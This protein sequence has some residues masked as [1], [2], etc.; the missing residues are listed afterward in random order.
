MTDPQEALRRVIETDVLGPRLRDQIAVL[1]LSADDPL[2]VARAD[3]LYLWDDYHTEMLDFAMT[4]SPLGHRHA[5]IIGTL[6]EH[7]NHYGFT[8]PQ[9]Q[10]ALRWPVLYAKD[11]SDSFS[12][13]S[14]A[15]KVLFCEGS[16][17][18]ISQAVLLARHH[19]ERF[20]TAVLDTGWHDWLPSR[21]LFSYDDWNRVDWA[22]YGALVMA[23]VDSSYAQV[24]AAREWMMSARTAG[25]P[26]I[27]DETVTGF[28]RTGL[29]WGQEHIGMVAEMTVLGGP[30][31][32][33]LPL[34]A[35]VGLPDFFTN[36]E[37]MSRTGPL[38]GHPWAC[39]AGQITLSAIHAG[40][41]EHVVE[42]AAVLS[43][44]LDGLQGQF[45][46]RITGHHGV[47]LL[48]AIRFHDPDRAAALPLAARAHGLHLPPAVGDTVL[49]APALVS[50]TYEVTRGV[51]LM[52]A[53]LMSW[54]DS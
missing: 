30:V 33:G 23:P 53:V 26:V 37:V 41:L 11:I 27:M 31:G 8:A 48:R 13:P 16:H 22:R 18:A 9:G 19:T 49:L 24:P 50:S 7:M 44:A 6:I 17:E 47:G 32:G 39:A 1:A 38:A 5:P 52:A 10:H 36:T 21:Q 3:L 51:D 25:V 15:R 34:G 20:E 35:V 2:P 14:E 12:G 45:P 43:T 28:G 42:S 29:L 54:E 4:V 46:D 40:V